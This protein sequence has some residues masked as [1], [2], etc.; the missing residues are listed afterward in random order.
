MAVRSKE[1]ILEKIRGRFSETP[2]DSDIEMLED[3]SDTFDSFEANSSEDWKSKYEENDAEWRKKY[4]S[5][6][7]DGVPSGETVA[8]E[9]KFPKDEDVSEDIMIEDLFKE[10]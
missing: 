9:E 7:F 2:T 4:T 8:S 1:E 6:F 3:I 10:E 5:R